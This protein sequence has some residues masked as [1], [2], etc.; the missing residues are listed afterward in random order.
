MNNRLLATKLYV[1]PARPELVPRPRL[2]EQL[3]AGLRFKL[4]LVSAPPG[5]GKTTLLSEC[6]T[7]CDW[8]VAWLSLDRGDNDPGRFWVYFIAA[9]QTIPA[10]HAAGDA[11]RAQ[12]RPAGL[13]TGPASAPLE[14]VLTGLLNDIA[15]IGLSPFILVLDDL[16]LIAE[17]QIHHGLTF[18]LDHLPPQF[19][20]ALSSRADPPWPLARLRARGDVAEM[21]AQ[22]LRFTPEEAATFLNNIM[23]LD[24]SPEDIAALEARTEGWIAGLQ[25]VAI[26]M[27]GRRRTHGAGGLSSFIKALTGSHRFILDYLVEEVLEQQSPDLQAFLLKT[28][29]LERLTAPLCD[30]VASIDDSQAVLAQL[31]QANLFLVP[32]DD[33]RRWYRYHHLFADL[34]CT[35]L[36]QHSTPEEIASLHRQ[37]GRWYEHN[38]LIA[39]AVGHALSAGDVDQVAHLAERNALAALYQGQVTTVVG[40]LDALPGEVVC[41]RPWLCIARAWVLASTGQ[42]DAVA[43]TLQDAERAAHEASQAEEQR[44]TAHILALRT[45]ATAIEGDLGGAKALARQALDRLPRE[46]LPVRSLVTLLLGSTLRHSGEL[47][48]AARIWTDAIDASR[49][50]GDSHGAVTLLSALAAIQ[51]EQ[52]QLRKAAANSREA[53]GLADEYVGRGGQPLQFMGPVHAR[54]S[55]L[56]REWNDPQAAVYHARQGLTLSKSWGHLEAIVT[57]HEA[58]AYALQAAGDADAALEAMDKARQASAGLSAW[59]EAR[60]AAAQARLWLILGDVAAA[61]RWS[62][63]S[64]GLEADTP[65]G[66]DRLPDYLTKAWTLIAQN[67]PDRALDLLARLSAMID[68]A[69]AAGFL[70]ESLVLRTMALQVRGE[71]EWT[72]FPLEHALF[73][74]EPEGYVRTFVDHGQLMVEPL[75]AILAEQQKGRP[76]AAWRIAPDYVVKLLTTL[77]IVTEEWEGPLHTGPRR[78]PPFGGHAGPTKIPVRGLAVGGRTAAEREAAQSKIRLVEPLSEREL[79]VL[80]L[81]STSLPTPDIADELFISVSTVRTHIKNIYGKLNVHNRIGAVERARELGLL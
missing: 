30:A 47:V 5:F 52:G 25:M 73:L 65:L 63:D 37:A 71:F 41:S 50:A 4:T 46:D 17:P 12:L 40:W 64:A 81:L 21:R 27:Q 36:E 68:A 20:L 67:R 72:V 33:E 53:L 19:H 38:D 77:G 58:L 80:H 11:A 56:Y 59:Y 14:T 22:D 48:A 16:H 74:A 78:S 34:L 66:F 3:K 76:A 75:T 6:A 31:E 43:L 62:D 35:R 60:T 29:V 26:S 24:L 45:Y 51:I 49:A 42:W 28:S 39:E 69:G 8:P 9:L 57:A 10:L 79:E 44:I 54:L 70:I 23:H 7:R 18:L 32:L 55:T 61:G 13:A 15:S 2:I 1:P